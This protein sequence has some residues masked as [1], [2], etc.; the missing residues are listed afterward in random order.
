MNLGIWLTEL[1]EA[2]F[3]AIKGVPHDAQETPNEGSR[4]S[5]ALRETVSVE[6]DSDAQATSVLFE[7]L[8]LG[9]ISLA[10]VLEEGEATL[11]RARETLTRDEC[12]VTEFAP[13]TDCDGEAVYEAAVL[14]E[15]CARKGLA[16]SL[17]TEHYLEKR[18]I[19]DLEV[20]SQIQK[21]EGVR[22]LVEAQ[23]T[24]ACDNL[25]ESI[26]SARRLKKD[27][28]PNCAEK[29]DKDWVWSN[30]PFYRF[31]A[32][33]LGDV[34]SMR[35]MVEDWPIWRGT[36]ALE[37]WSALEGQID[38]AIGYLVTE[39]PVEALRLKHHFEVKRSPTTSYSRYAAGYLS[40]AP[41]ES[42][43]LIEATAILLAYRALSEGQTQPVDLNFL[44]DIEQRR[45]DTLSPN[46]LSLA[47]SRSQEMLS[48]YQIK[49]GRLDRQFIN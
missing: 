2:P 1:S 14:L 33:L 3:E 21:F 31:Q 9:G 25:S 47:I 38:N 40:S 12:R 34:R 18:G 36:L 30:L 22:S 42:E 17:Y 43:R 4:E 35:W 32:A 39:D 23:V 27:I 44:N 16:P 26:Q 11:S 37:D 6:S 5:V 24:P 48:E 19:T 45:I 41:E 7:Q 15:L 13:N 10:G 46:D 28:C 29:S 8:D 49:S 20:Y